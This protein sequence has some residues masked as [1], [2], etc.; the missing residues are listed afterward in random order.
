MKEVAEINGLF[1]EYREDLLVLR[2]QRTDQDAKDSRH[3]AR[4]AVMAASKKM[5]EQEPSEIEL[6]LP[7]HAAGALTPRDARKVEEALA[8]DPALAGRYALIRE[9]H[10]GLMDLNGSLGTPSPRVMQRLF[11]AID[12]EPRKPAASERMAVRFLFPGASPA[13][14]VGDRAPHAGPELDTSSAGRE[15]C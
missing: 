2:A 13:I 11:A 5:I 15:T 12:A 9:E 14:I 1:G 7:W 6:L 4:L 10:A 3:T 8:R